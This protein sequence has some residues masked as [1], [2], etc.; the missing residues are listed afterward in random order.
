MLV[1]FIRSALVS[2]SVTPGH[3]ICLNNME[4]TMLAQ[5]ISRATQQMESPNVL[6]E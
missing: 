5:K 3:E 6:L 2:L 4:A 1:Y